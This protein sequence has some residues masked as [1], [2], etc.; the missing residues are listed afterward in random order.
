MIAVALAGGGE[1]VV[2]WEAGVLSGLRVRP[3]VVLGTSAGALVAARFAAGWAPHDDVMPGP[4]PA[5]AFERLARAWEAAGV[6]LQQRRRTLGR[7]GA[8]RFAGRR[9]GVRPPGRRPA[10]R[11]RGP[12]RCGS[13]P[14]TPSP[15]SA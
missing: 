8:D 7:Q 2:A 15:A 3:D 4:H 13:R 14:S 9:G 11:T 6:T 10:C 1:R 5:A 12:R